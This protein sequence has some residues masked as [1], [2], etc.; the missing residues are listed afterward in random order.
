MTNIPIPAGILTDAEVSAAAAISASKVIHRDCTQYSQAIGSIVASA[1][2]LIRVARASGTLKEFRVGWQTA[3]TGGDKKFTVDL[4]QSTGGGAFASV[5]SAVVTVDNAK[6]NNG[7]ATGTL[8]AS[9]FV[10]GDLFQVVVAASG[11][12][13]TQGYGMIAEAFFEE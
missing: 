13:G 12:T 10:T 8:T 9:S 3:P 11:S 1:T 6:S 5:L 2:Q 7:T 4:Q